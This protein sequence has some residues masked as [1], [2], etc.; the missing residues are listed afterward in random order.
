MISAVVLGTNGAGLSGCVLRLWAI[1]WS[2]SSLISVTPTMMIVA[3][4]Y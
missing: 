4:Y 2:S 1:C 3:V